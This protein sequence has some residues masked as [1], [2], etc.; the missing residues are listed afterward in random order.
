[1]FFSLDLLRMKCLRSTHV[2]PSLMN[3]LE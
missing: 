3:L 1:M 2:N